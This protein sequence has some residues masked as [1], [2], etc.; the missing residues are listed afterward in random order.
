MNW[1]ILLVLVS[2]VIYISVKMYQAGKDNVK[3]KVSKET[4]EY[5]A[6][7]KKAS[8]APLSDDAI[9]KLRHRND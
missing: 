8:E 7:A 3:A 4:L 2:A 9:N 1:Y 5:V 6:K